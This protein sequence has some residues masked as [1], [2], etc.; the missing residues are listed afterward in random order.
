VIFQS[1]T[2]TI[3]LLNVS[4]MARASLIGLELISNSFKV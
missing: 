4:N 3:D 1:F 2:V